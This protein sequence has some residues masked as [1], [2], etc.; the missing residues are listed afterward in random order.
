MTRIG[1]GRALAGLGVVTL[2]TLGGAVGCLDRPVAQTHPTTNNVFVDQVPQG[3]VSKIDLLFM[4]DNSTSMADKQDILRRAVPALVQRLTSPNCLTDDLTHPVPSVDGKCTTGRLEFPAVSDIHVGIVT[5]SLGSHGG[6]QCSTAMGPGYTP[7]DKAHLLGTVRQTGSNSA[8]LG[9]FDSSRTWNNSGFL[10]W[11]ATQTDQ[12]PGE[13]TADA[14][15][16]NFQDMVTAA[17][18]HGCGY[19]ASLES[20]YRFLV[21][22][23]P[24]ANVTLQ[25]GNTVRGSHLTVNPDGSTSCD[26][27]DMDLLAQRKAFLRPDSLVAIVMLSDENDCSI[28][29]KDKGWFVGSSSL[30]PKSTA[31][32]ATNPNDP[33]CRSCASAET[34]PP[35]N[36]VPLNQDPVCM[37][38]SAGSYQTWDGLHDA[39]NL[40]CF[41]QKQ[42]FG[43]DLLYP[44]D[45]YVNALTAAQLTLQSDDKTIVPN[46]L[47]AGDAAHAP[48]SPS[49]VFLAGIVG[50]PWQDIA[51]D[52]SL[53]DPNQLTY[54]DADALKAQGRWDV[55]LGDSSAKP[56]VPPSDPFMLESIGPRQ[57][58][59]PITNDPI[60]APD[61]T[62]PSGINGHEYNVPKLDDLQ[63][64]CTFELTTPKPCTAGDRACDCAAD[65]VDGMPDT[66]AITAANSPLCQ[67][68]AGGAVGTT[69]YFAKAYP[70]L[71]ELQVLHDFPNNGIVAS[72]CPKISAQDADEADVNFGYNPAVGAIIAR[73]KTVL[74]GSCL[75]RPPATVKTA[76]GGEAVACQVIE[77]RPMGCGDCSEPGRVPLGPEDQ[78]TIQAVREELKA[79]KLCD[80]DG[81]PA[82][83]T[84]CQC[85]IRAEDGSDLV[86]CQKDQTPN[87]PG[88]CYIDDAASPAVANCPANQKRILRFADSPAS[89]IPAPGAYAF[90][91]CIGAAVS[92][93]DAGE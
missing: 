30:M 1:F 32:C 62:S 2:V 46:P 92:G 7:D 37:G 89:P 61:S 76:G 80:V 84:F 90:V 88:Y 18:Q 27:C 4:I 43:F 49:L 67:P 51:D 54:L 71:R 86:A 53:K 68:K 26:G 66:T 74:G 73:L 22:P 65:L 75:P 52:T 28:I 48:R 78:P 11:D 14:F 10:A 77:T 42:R 12:P 41:E 83:D 57:G 70:G 5:S 85:G 31:V 9:A 93:A 21:D 25:N 13:N 19:E 35:V 8:A 55:I 59:N 3:N 23:E 56:P 60:V 36:C 72:I 58:K 64:A 44:T 17:G 24:P 39:P 63:Y 91:G 20:W 6:T 50:V 33:C 87:Q 29:D 15:K 16:S 81:R 34:T 69:Q 82:C 38:A 79:S 40:R 47:F 45:R